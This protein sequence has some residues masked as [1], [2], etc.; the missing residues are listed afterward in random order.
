MRIED[1]LEKID[2]KLERIEGDMAT[3]KITLAL[4]NQSLDTHMKRSA[5]NEEAVELLRL[6]LKP[7]SLHIAVVSGILKIVVGFGVLAGIVATLNSLFHFI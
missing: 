3:A 2:A 6:E 1:W 7:V 5:A 4:H